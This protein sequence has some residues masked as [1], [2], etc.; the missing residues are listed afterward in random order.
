M[1]FHLLMDTFS[2]VCI[3]F[4]VALELLLCLRLFD[5]TVMSQSEIGLWKLIRSSFLKGFCC[6]KG[7]LSCFIDLS[8]VHW[9]ICTHWIRVS[10]FTYRELSLHHFLFK[11]LTFILICWL[12]ILL[13][14]RNSILRLVGRSMSSKYKVG[15]L[16]LYTFFNRSIWRLSLSTLI[17]LFILELELLWKLCWIFLMLIGGWISRLESWCL[18][19]S[20]MGVLNFDIRRISLMLIWMSISLWVLNSFEF[21]SHRID[22][23]IQ[24]KVMRICIQSINI[25]SKF[26][27]SLSQF[28][29]V[30]GS[31]LISNFKLLNLVVLLIHLFR[32]RLISW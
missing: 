27:M 14:I 17:N 3:R 2:Q 29:S 20:T 5:C 22:S 26:K 8:Y 28:L 18:T 12:S 15:F 10:R 32:N 6:L 4:P 1:S 24:T 30:I 16:K 31:F 19:C 7:H 11:Y 23:S 9:L 21:I 13:M 25:S